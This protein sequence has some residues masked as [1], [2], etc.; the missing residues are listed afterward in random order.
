MSLSNRLIAVWLLILTGVTSAFPATAAAQ[1]FRVDTEIFENQDKKPILE[2]LTIFAKDGT[3][4]DLRLSEPK[5]VTV[6]DLRRGVCTLLDESRRVKSIVTT[7][8]LLDVTL[9][10]QTHAEQSKSS[11]IA[12]CAAPKFEIA[13]KAI[14]RDGQAL[15]EL[16]LSSK[17][18]TYVVEA[19]KAERPETV[20]AYRQFADWC[21]RL[22]ATVSGNL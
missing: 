19:E 14:N 5:E 15:T 8:E 7:Q 11:L 21:V 2:Q 9:E 22:N 18:L 16:Q 6:F 10:L 4:Y 3:I 1:E 13:E 17:P 20:K 12:F